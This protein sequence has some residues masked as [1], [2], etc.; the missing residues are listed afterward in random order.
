M[1]RLA[2]LLLLLF[3]TGLIVLVATTQRWRL[4]TERR[5][6]RLSTEAADSS[7]VARRPPVTG[8]TATLS[9]AASVG[10][11]LRVA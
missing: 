6:E 8:S 7:P 3:A 4:S 9:T 2:T 1:S 11:P 5:D 10:M